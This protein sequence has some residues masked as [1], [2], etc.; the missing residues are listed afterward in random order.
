MPGSPSS[1]NRTHNNQ[2]FDPE[3]EGYDMESA[4]ESGIKPD[5]ETKHW[6]SRVPSGPKEGLLLKGKK[7][8]TWDLLEKGEKEAGYEIFKSGGRYYSRE[9]RGK[10]M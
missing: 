8:E 4:V 2:N 3:G 10:G 5:P 6:P 9:K 1:Y 7:H